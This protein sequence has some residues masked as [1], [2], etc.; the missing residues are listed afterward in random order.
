MKLVSRVAD[1]WDSRSY[2]T[3][4]HF[5]SGKVYLCEQSFIDL[6]KE[7]LLKKIILCIPSIPWQ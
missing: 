7:R 6:N 4:N 5:V 1:G 2:P 3:T